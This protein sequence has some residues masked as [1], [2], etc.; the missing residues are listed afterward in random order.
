MKRWARWM[1]HYFKK[2]LISEHVKKRLYIMYPKEET[3]VALERYYIEKLH[4]VLI[5]MTVGLVLA[6]ISTISAFLT[7][8]TVDELERGEYGQGIKKYQIQLE[9]ED[10]SQD[11]LELSVQERQ[12]TLEELEMLY[13][14]VLPQVEDFM[15]LDNKGVDEITGNL[16]LPESMPGYPFSIQWS[17]DRVDVVGRDG[18]LLDTLK[19]DTKVELKA[20]FQYLLEG[21]NEKVFSKEHKWNLILH[22]PKY[23][24]EEI[25]QDALKE[26]LATSDQN[27]KFTDIRELPQQ[28]GTKTVTWSVKK[29]YIG[30]K[31][32]VLTMLAI[33]VTYFLKDQELE[34]LEKERNKELEEGYNTLVHKLVIYMGAG[35]PIRSAWER[36][37]VG[38]GL[39]AGNMGGKVYLSGELKHTCQEM[40][41]GVPEMVC[42]ERFG[43][44]CGLP[45][46]MKLGTL[47]AQNIKKGNRI[48][49]LQ[50]KEEAES[51]L[52]DTKHRTRRAAEEAGTKLLGPMMLMLAM[53]LILIMVPAF[54]GFL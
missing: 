28:I 47:L 38:M 37:A 24:E 16:Q 39:S 26:A 22:P 9:Q 54:S 53:V 23:T 52:E 46:Y 45:R 11:Q 21:E 27:S 30:K 49:L 7:E 1:Y 8:K 17:R 15:L 19:E 43:R 6:S 5:I 51:S 34:K 13:Q 12:Y 41:S 36:I 25:W 32:L 29:E 20:S 31:V 3:E 35:M 18:A 4:L 48:L 44:R 2:F 33:L 42:Y 50:L 14:K 40:Q 10:G